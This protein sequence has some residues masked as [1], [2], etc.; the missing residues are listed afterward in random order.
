MPKGLT[1]TFV[2]GK[3]A[4]PHFRYTKGYALRICVGFAAATIYFFD[5]EIAVSKKLLK[6]Y[7]KSN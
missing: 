1:I 2:F 5:Y 4:K 7:F 3:Y 6:H